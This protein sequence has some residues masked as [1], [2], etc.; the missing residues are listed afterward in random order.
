MSGQDIRKWFSKGK[1]KAAEATAKTEVVHATSASSFA[2]G[3]LRTALPVDASVAA[4]FC[5]FGPYRT[6]LLSC[7]PARLLAGA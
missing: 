3:L 4:Y 7:S 6:F 5:D 1:P 2:Q